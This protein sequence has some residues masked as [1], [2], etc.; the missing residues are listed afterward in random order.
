MGLTAIDTG[1]LIAF[2]D[3]KDVF[4]ASATT[5]LMEA[6]AGGPTLLPGI[7]YAEA[8][9]MM[10]RIDVE[11][12]WFD[13]MLDRLRISAGSCTNSV[14]KRGAELRASSLEDRRRRQWK[15][16][17]ALIMAESIEAGARLILTTDAGWPSLPD[18][19]QVEVLSA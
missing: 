16:P 2:L 9:V 3:R 14:L 7:A 1:V 10:R 11:A 18:G 19:P 12:D 4:H 13:Q 8:L 6:I 15:L 5:G 17:D